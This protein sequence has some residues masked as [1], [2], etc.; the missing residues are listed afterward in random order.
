MQMMCATSFRMG[1]CSIE[2]GPKKSFSK[3]HFFVAVH[4]LKSIA[5]ALLF[6]EFC[7]TFSSVTLDRLECVR[8]RHALA[9]S[10]IFIDEFI[11]R[12]SEMVRRVCVCVA[13]DHF[14][15]YSSN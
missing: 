12:N 10:S 14:N 11:A 6:T 9:A 5:Y 2:V 1:Q 8:M 13:L 4:S 7:A 15:V 3:E